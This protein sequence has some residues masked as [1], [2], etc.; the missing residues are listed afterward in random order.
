MSAF[1]DLKTKK[2]KLEFIK[3]GLLSNDRWVL[4]GLLTIYKHQT[5]EEQVAMAVTEHNGV[6]FTG[7]DGEILSSFAQRAIRCGVP[8]K[9]EAN[10]QITVDEVFTP[11][12]A[13]ILRKKMP[14]YAG[15]LMRI[16]IEKE[17]MKK[18][19][20]QNSLL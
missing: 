20:Q 13:D 17:E 8:A 9:L 15:Q 11:K 19:Q 3:K 12:Q 1:S 4:S 18:H 14:K 10:Q 2:A 6:G 16:A 7:I 5:S